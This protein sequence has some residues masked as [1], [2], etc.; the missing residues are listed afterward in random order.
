MGRREFYVLE[1]SNVVTLYGEFGLGMGLLWLH[2]VIRK[3]A[4]SRVWIKKLIIK[5]VNVRSQNRSLSLPF[6]R[7]TS[8]IRSV[9]IVLHNYSVQWWQIVWIRY[10][11]SEKGNLLTIKWNLPNSQFQLVQFIGKWFSPSLNTKGAS[12]ADHNPY[13]RTAILAVSWNLFIKQLLPS[14]SNFDDNIVF[15]YSVDYHVT[16]SKIDYYICS[17]RDQ[18]IVRDLLSCYRNYVA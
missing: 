1:G 4:S 3:T 5:Q 2:V 9:L 16:L 11:V 7:S 10:Y 12:L 18:E 8:I 6:L 17:S 13:K 15:Q 14:S